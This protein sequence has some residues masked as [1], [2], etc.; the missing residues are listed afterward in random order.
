MDGFLQQPKEAAAVELIPR[1]ISY[2]SGE[3]LWE[4]LCKELVGTL[5]KPSPLFALE[6][7]ASLARAAHQV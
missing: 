5:G 3:R 4:G 1:V 6:G 2:F 7:Q